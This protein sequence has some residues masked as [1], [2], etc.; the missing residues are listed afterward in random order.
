MITDYLVLGQSSRLA[1][2]FIQL[3]VAEYNSKFD[4]N[5]EATSIMNIRT[6]ILDLSKIKG[7][8]NYEF[9]ADKNCNISSSNTSNKIH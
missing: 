1:K 8:L 6:Y 3:L 9:I 2:K 7:N 4:N 5:L